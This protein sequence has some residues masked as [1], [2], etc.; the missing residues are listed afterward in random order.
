MKEHAHW[1]IVN[2]WAN[3][4]IVHA[5]D[6]PEPEDIQELQAGDDIVVI[7]DGNHLLAFNGYYRACLLYTSRCV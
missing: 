1:N 7:E 5:Y 6:S 4:P 3:T 2:I